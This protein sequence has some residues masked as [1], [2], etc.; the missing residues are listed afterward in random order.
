MI[1]STWV[2]VGAW[3]WATV[4]IKKKKKTTR[5]KC[6]KKRISLTQSLL[7]QL[8]ILSIS[9]INCVT[10]NTIKTKIEIDIKMIDHS[11]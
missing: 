7:Q 4:Q 9:P 11:N 3:H 6:N 5:T 1:C 8:L 10:K 2:S